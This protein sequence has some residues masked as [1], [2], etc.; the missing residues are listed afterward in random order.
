MLDIFIALF[1][2]YVVYRTTMRF[3]KGDINSREYTMWLVFWAL[4]VV[5]TLLPQKT[6]IIARALGVERG[7]DLL[8][9]VSIIVLFFAVFKIIV[10]LEKIDR[11]ITEVVRRAAIKN[12]EK[13]DE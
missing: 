3:R 9:F 1:V 8:F 5:A 12:T 11:N 7:A 4:V 10:K 2:A 13:K 6:D